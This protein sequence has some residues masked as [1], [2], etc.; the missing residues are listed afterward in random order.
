MMLHYNNYINNALKQW[1]RIE[2][3]GGMKGGDGKEQAERTSVRKGE[4]QNQRTTENALTKEL[5][6]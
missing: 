4:R 1:F 2:H 6:Q 5:K 3:D